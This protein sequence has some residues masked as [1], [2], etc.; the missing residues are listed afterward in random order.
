MAA[1][2]QQ[3]ASS[4]PS[5]WRLAAGALAAGALFL[6]LPASAITLQQA[7]EKA[8]Q[9]DPTFRVAYYGNQATRE[10]SNIARSYL[11]PSVSGSYSSSEAKSDITVGKTTSHREYMSKSANVSLR[12]AIFNLEALARYRQGVAQGLA[13]DAQL[14][15]ARQTL[16]LRVVAAYIDAIYTE[17][18]LALGRA[19]RDLLAE[20]QKVND[21][22][23]KAGEGTVTDRLETQAKLDLAEARLLELEDAQRAARVT[24]A[25]IIGEEVQS[26][27][28]LR[29]DF[30][31]RPSDRN[32]YKDWV[33]VALA[34]NPELQAYQHSITAAHEEVN[35]AR[36]GHV[37][38][39]DF[40]ASI[41]KA[42][43]ESI[44]TLG[45][46]SDTKS[47]GFQMSVPIFSGGAISA[48]TRQARATEQRAKA[49]LD[50]K[51][52]AVMVDL[53]KEYDALTSSVARI[54]ALE[55]AVESAQLLMKATEQ[56]IK[57]G[58]R[59]NLDL[60]NAQESR[61]LAERDLAQAR[62]NYLLNTLRLR[63]ASGTLSGDDV[64]D[65]G[66]YFT[67]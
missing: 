6:H 34:R 26:L 39:V 11:L 17:D 58:V 66:S 10:N 48:S 32:S 43:S 31:V 53:R 44:S 29:P 56:S 64:R 16:I 13:S 49:E 42:D 3:Q 38:R 15:A 5:R 59:I 47:I 35:R 50:A 7:Y 46:D 52:A 19:Q 60:L 67:R 1:K 25:G 4:A 28:R 40:V 18:Q 33:A 41:S 57:G 45:Q 55:K 62:Y 21:R 20:Q 12:Q 37:P 36:A 24:L 22:L 9:H 65:L 14:E 27:D 23:Y 51:A 63:A 2:K 8:V 54:A 61:Y 30:A